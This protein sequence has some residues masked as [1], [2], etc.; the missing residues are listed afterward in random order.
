M[1]HIKMWRELRGMI[2]EDPK[3]MPKLKGPFAWLTAI[4]LCIPGWYGEFLTAH[5]ITITPLGTRTEYMVEVFRDPQDLTMTQWAWAAAYIDMY[6]KGSPNGP[7][8]DLMHSAQDKDHSLILTHMQPKMPGRYDP[9]PLPDPT[10]APPVD[11][12]TFGPMDENTVA[13]D[14][15]KP[16]PGIE[17]EAGP[18]GM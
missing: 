4:L 9:P 3:T 14:D 10:P 7:H 11:A 12:S 8:I 1:L 2:P 6:I 5:G 15:D 17:D 18:A 13:L 16:F